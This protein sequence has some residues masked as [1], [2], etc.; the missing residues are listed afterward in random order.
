M[1][2]ELARL[3]VIENVHIDPLSSTERKGPAVILL[4]DQAPNACHD[5]RPWVYGFEVASGHLKNKA[6]VCRHGRNKPCSPFDTPTSLV[7][8]RII[9]R[10]FEIWQILSVMAVLHYGFRAIT[11]R[12]CCKM[13][14]L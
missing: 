3:V 14:K 9:R 7:T 10:D 2:E 11:L 8:F 5:H 1:G 4:I 13:N 6:H 12:D